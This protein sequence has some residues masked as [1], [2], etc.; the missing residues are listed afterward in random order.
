M[1]YTDD[2]ADDAL[3]PYLPISRPRRSVAAIRRAARAVR[4]L[5]VQ[6]EALQALRSR[7]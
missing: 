1:R 4:V 7:A 6:A 5:F 2:R 3:R